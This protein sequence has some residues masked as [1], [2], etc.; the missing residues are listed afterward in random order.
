MMLQFHKN[1]LSTLLLM[2]LA[3][4]TACSTTEGQR[5]TARA[6]APAQTAAPQQPEDG[7][8][9]EVRG[10]R[11]PIQ[12]G[13]TATELPS[14]VQWSEAP[15]AGIK[16]N[17]N[18]ADI[19]AVADALLGDALGITYSIADGVNGRMTVQTDGS[20][21]RENLLFV[22][23]EALDS[24]GVVLQR[25]EQGYRLVPKDLVA[26]APGAVPVGLT[27]ADLR[28]GYGQHFVPLKFVSASRLLVTLSS[29]S[30]LDV[31]L[32]VDDPRNLLILEGSGP[33][34]RSALEMIRIFDVNW[35][36]GRAYAL[37][38]LLVSEPADLIRELETIFRAD[39]RGLAADV[40]D[41]LPIDRMNAVLVIADSD[42]LLQSA[43]SWIAKLDVGGENAGKRLYTYSVQNGRATDL[44]A[45]LGGLFGAQ[46][47]TIGRSG[48]AV[49][50]GLQ[51]GFQTSAGGPGGLAGAQQTSAGQ[52]GQAGTRATVTQGG[53]ATT[54]A[55]INDTMRI[56]ADERNNALLI[57]TSPADY[58]LIRNSLRR[59]DVKPLQVL[60]E[61]TI[62][63]VNLNDDLRY[64]VQ[65]FFESGDFNFGLTGGPNRT[66][67]GPT[68]PGFTGVFDDLAD[69]RVVV[70]AL[71]S[72]TN[73]ELLSSPQLMVLNN[74]TA[75]LQ[76]GDEVPIPQT[77]A[78]N[79]NAGTNTV[80]NSITYR[81]TGIILKVTPR[82]NASGT[83]LLDIE[84]EVSDVSQTVSSGIDAP[85]VQQ[86]RIVSS[87]AVESGETLALGGLIQ[88]SVTEIDRGVPLLSEIPLLGNLFK[89]TTNSSARSEL[90]ILVTPRLVGSTE[91]ARSVTNELEARM[92][93]LERLLNE[94]RR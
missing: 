91:Q 57:L 67:P 34:R 18:N 79:L 11:Q 17:F 6:T 63:E 74:Q 62:L 21:S 69:A 15:G 87:V 32:K 81:S 56:V 61:A 68:V 16:L 14:T 94:N 66:T 72:V 43:E 48:G 78:V 42:E 39:D 46:Q 4:L 38:P 52:G 89:S 40:I 20:L 64:G 75:L 65:W 33:A 37:V 53:G 73:V 93:S 19:R 90:L 88:S 76:V 25:L 45:V 77:N 35:M 22:F 5:E 83:V 8:V 29:M 2:A 9:S 58:G 50:P 36:Q 71:D 13:R 51:S 24:V 84:Q 3:A 85:T 49:A 55:F 60:I 70:D 47:Q 7:P 86:R 10:F 44:A 92:Q 1:S 23:E 80:F 59:L 30:G 28:A 54:M 26:G 31:K 12:G 27:A 41:F 82:V